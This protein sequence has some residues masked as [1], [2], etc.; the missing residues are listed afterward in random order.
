V[1]QCRE[2]LRSSVV[3]CFLIEVLSPTWIILAFV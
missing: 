2:Q 3:P 1:R